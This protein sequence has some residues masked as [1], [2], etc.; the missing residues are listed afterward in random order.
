MSRLKKS[1]GV[2]V[3]VIL[4][5]V[6]LSLMLSNLKGILM[7]AQIK[8]L[9]LIPKPLGFIQSA[10]SY[11]LFWLAL[12][13]SVIL[14]IVLLIIVFYPKN[15]TEIDL[16]EDNGKLILKSSA[17]DGLVKSLVIQKGF[18]KNPKVTTRL[19]KKK[20]KVRVKGDVVTKHS[21][22]AQSE[23]VK[24]DITQAL[25]QFIG[26]NQ[27]LKLQVEIAGVDTPKRLAKQNSRVE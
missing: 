4:L 5:I 7:P 6:S 12:I 16:A 22:I 11:Y 26:L 24:A 18:M 9:G 8:V 19:Y 10:V 15:K 3:T 13:V 1:V 23:V 21:V 14:L 27:P 2:I 20:L 17:I 25:Q